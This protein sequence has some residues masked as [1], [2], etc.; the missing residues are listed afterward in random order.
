MTDLIIFIESSQQLKQFIDIAYLPTDP[1]SISYEYRYLSINNIMSE[2]QDYCLV[3]RDQPF[4]K[5]VTWC[6]SQRLKF[7]K[8][9]AK[10]KHETSETRSSLRG[11]YVLKDSYKGK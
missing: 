9:E 4:S 11:V 10:R 7:L 2:V 3:F 5:F 1:K 8:T 6:S